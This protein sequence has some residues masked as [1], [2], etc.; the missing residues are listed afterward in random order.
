MGGVPGRDFLAKINLPMILDNY[1]RPVLLPQ[2]IELLKIKKGG[3]YIDATVGFGGYA[4]EIIK[5]KGYV[6]GIDK[7][8]FPLRILKERKI[9]NLDLYHGNYADLTVI[10]AKKGISCVDGIIFDFGLSSYQIEQSNRGFSFQKNEP[11]DMRFDQRSA[12]KAVD[13]VNKYQAEELYEIFTKYS[14]ELYSRSIAEAIVRTR[15]LKGDIKTSEKLRE[16]ILAGIKNVKSVN[17]NSVLARI[18]QAI[19]IEVNSDLINIEKGLPQAASLL[20]EGGRLTVISYHSLE[21]RLV[22]KFMKQ[23]ARNKELLIITRSPVIPD[24]QEIRE[25]SSSRSAKL[26]VAEKL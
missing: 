9:A 13:I 7:D 20:R 3:S 16:T 26:R 8:E 11:L 19:R 24:Y 21:D 18:F 17:K 1:H 6:L 4:L 25:N 5:R 22:K 12:L 23:T 14:E 2:V 10:A 15:T